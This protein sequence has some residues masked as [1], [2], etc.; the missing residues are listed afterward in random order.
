MPKYL[1][2]ELGEDAARQQCGSVAFKMSMLLKSLAHKQVPWGSVNSINY[3]MC[4][5][6]PPLITVATA[7]WRT[8][9]LGRS[10]RS[11]VA[12]SQSS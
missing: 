1:V 6:L 2:R 7:K 9:E 10:V 12:N 4:A 3:W 11:G 8:L 5:L